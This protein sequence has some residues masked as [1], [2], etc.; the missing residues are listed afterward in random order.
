[1]VSICHPSYLTT[2]LGR[3]DDQE[4]YP[5]DFKFAWRVPFTK[6]SSAKNGF[7]KIRSYG[8]MR[9]ERD[10]IENRKEWVLRKSTPMVRGRFIEFYFEQLD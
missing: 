6:K 8:M 7:C 3:Q 10:V 5:G 9:E 4:A 2:D 1:M